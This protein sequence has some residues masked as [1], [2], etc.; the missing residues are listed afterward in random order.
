[1]RV[2]ER[3]TNSTNPTNH[4]SLTKTP[5]EPTPLRRETA[6]SAV[7]DVGGPVRAKSARDD[8][9]D[10]INLGEIIAVLLEY[11]WLILAVTFFAVFIGAVTAFVS[12]P[13]Y[14]ADALV[15]VED[16]KSAK[17]GLAAL[18][19]VEAVL[20]D[21]TSVAAELEILRSRMILGRVVD[22]LNLSIRANPDYFP[23]FGRALARRYNGDEPAAPFLGLGTYAWGGER[24]DVQSLEVPSYLQGLPLTLIAGDNNTF[25]LYD[26]QDMR[27]LEG[28]VGQAAASADGKTTLF[29]AELVARPGTRFDLA[30]VGQTQ[31]IAALRDN[32]EVRERAR[33]S[34][35]IE[36]A[37]SGVDRAQVEA[38]LNEILNAYV[39]QNVEYRSAEAEATLGFLEAQ[40]PELKGQLDTAEAAYN[41]Y[42]QNRGSVDLTI[43]TQSVLGSI[44]KVDNDI[45]VLQQKRDELRQ[46][47]TAEHPQVKAIDSQLGRLRA[48]R[49]TLDK[50]VNRL[51]DTQQTALRLRRD[52]EVA[53]ALYTNLLNSAQQLRVARAGTVGDVRV[54][55]SAATAPLPVAPRKAL[56]LLLSGVLGVLGALGLVW[57]IR[58]LRVVV[59]DPQTIE[60]ELSLPVYATVPDSKEEAVLSRAISRGKMDKGQLLALAHPDDDAMES[61]RSLRTTLHFALLGAEKGSVLIT[62]PAPG[63]GKSFI[64]KNLG[65]VLAQAGKRVMLV[66]GDLRKGHI[67]KAFGVQ[68]GM[69]VSDYI[70]GVAGLEQIVKPT[71]IDNFALVTTGQIPPN[72]SELL[73]HPRF[74]ELLAALEKQ[75]DVLIIDAPPVLAVSDAAIIGRQV[76]A[77][78]LVAR[79]GRHPVRELEQAIKRFDQAGVEVKGF[80]FNGF[81]L[82]RQ[83]HRF[84]YEGYHYQ[85]KY[86]A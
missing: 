65:A 62:G 57:A 49:G 30:R 17:G 72:P 69:G 32:L 12:T 60:R 20:G 82:T 10:F 61:L 25:T 7:A 33:Q 39:R 8:K 29:I 37:Y 13:I 77:T 59:E 35:V 55:D 9:D 67:N 46:R 28:S 16:K 31:A 70:M 15:Q 42:R 81:D 83:R 24:I 6:P 19:D 23:V 21:T 58:S 71:G 47:F 53:T 48:V 26:D 79:A 5:Q 76:G 64:S 2:V 11:K 84:G 4:N 40:L 3:T 74:A 27:L 63:V 45:V 38:V 56:I 51:P 86:K 14:R 75:C 43:E 1:M 68:R 44:V 34:N 73:M 54:I 78:L 50:D 85:Y 36:A 66:D 80:V 41:E 52:V 22:R 18:R